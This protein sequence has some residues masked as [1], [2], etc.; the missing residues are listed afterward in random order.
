MNSSF[1]S[2]FRLLAL[3]EGPDVQWVKKNERIIYVTKRTRIIVVACFKK[4]YSE[5]S[6]DTHLCSRWG[7]SVFPGMQVL[8]S[9][10]ERQSVAAGFPSRAITL[11][12]PPAHRPWWRTKGCKEKKKWGFGIKEGNKRAHKA[13]KWLFK[14]YC[15]CRLIIKSKSD[16]D[17]VWNFIDQ[18]IVCRQL[19]R[20]EERWTVYVIDASCSNTSKL[21]DSVYLMSNDKCED[22]NHNITTI[23]LLLFTFTR[24]EKGLHVYVYTSINNCDCFMKEW[25]KINLCC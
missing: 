22:T 12:A 17:P 25:N 24:R 10:T 1:R 2:A 6:V 19:Q 15:T 13:Y 5:T 18:T 14:F 11:P 20:D 9:G 3:N 8:W 4:T 16:L 7:L 21:M 23:F